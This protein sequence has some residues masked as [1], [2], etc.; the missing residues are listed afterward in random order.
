[1]TLRLVFHFIYFT[2][3]SKI[4]NLN[5]IQVYSYKFTI[6]RY[7]HNFVVSTVSDII[8]LVIYEEF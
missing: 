1:M 5:D 2:N 3:N 6:F 7:C 4:K 8:I